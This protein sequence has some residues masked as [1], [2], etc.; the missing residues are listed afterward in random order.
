MEKREPT[1]GELLDAILQLRDYVDTGLTSLRQEF[2]QDLSREIGTVQYEIGT[3]RHDMN[4]RFD[5]VDER[6]DRM[7]ARFDALELRVGRLEGRP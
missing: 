1:T 6:F 5:R 7:D 2:R 3:L 4:R